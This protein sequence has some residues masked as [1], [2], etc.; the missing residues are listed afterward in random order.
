MNE[1]ANYEFFAMGTN[2]ELQL[3]GDSARA[4]SAAI[5]E[6]ERIERT[7][8][9]YRQ[10]GIVHA[11]NEAAEAGGTIGVDGETADLID[12][13]FEAYRL[14]DGLFDITSGVLRELWNN[15]TEAL[16]GAAGIEGVL[17]RIGLHKVFWRRPELTFTL[18]RMQIDLGGIGKEYAADR[19][20]EICRSLGV[21]HGMV[22]LGGDI[23]IIGPHPGGEPWRIGVRDPKA[24]E[25]AIATLFVSSGGVATSGDYERYWVIEGR[26]FG[27]I[28]NPLT[29][30]P[31][32]GLSSVTVGAQTCLAAGLYSTIAMLKGVSGPRWLREQ[33]IVHVFVDASGRLDLSGIERPGAAALQDSHQ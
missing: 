11:I 31:A 26:R 20:A 22:N 1:P 3:Y 32:S 16:P 7:Y 23:A 27:H 15:R 4:A 29:G 21:Q 14:S 12:T 5:G 30:W 28:L 9:R 33:G 18:P 6:V 17:S 8:S 25:T 2:C 24:L 10:D 13:A 19:A